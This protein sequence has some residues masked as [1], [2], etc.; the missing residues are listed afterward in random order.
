MAL[1]DF[2]I[3][4]LRRT[5]TYLLTYSVSALAVDYVR[6][7]SASIAL[8]LY[9]LNAV[10]FS[11]RSFFRAYVRNGGRGANDIIMRMTSQ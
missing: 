6:V 11:V 7:V 1:C 2:D 8:Y 5:L 3:R 9:I 10:M 4:R